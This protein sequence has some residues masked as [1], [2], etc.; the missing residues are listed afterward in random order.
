MAATPGALHF[1]IGLNQLL[2]IDES[3][4]LA[5]LA[6]ATGF[7]RVSCA[8]NLFMR[9]VWPILTLV[10]RETKHVEVGPLVTHPF[11]THPAVI[12]G[13]VAELDEISSGRAFIGIG[14]GAFYD[15]LQLKPE[16]PVTAVRE[17]IEMIAQ[18]L[19]G[20]RR[21][22]RGTVFSLAE[23]AALRWQPPRR[24]MPIVV[25]SWGPK[26]AEI[27]G[28]LAH[29]IDVGFL[30]NLDHIRVVKEHLEL[31]ARR[32]GRDPKSVAVG[33]GSMTAVASD[34]RAAL[35]FARHHLSLF[36]P[37]LARVPGYP[38]VDPAEVEAVESALRRGGP[39]EAARHIGDSTVTALCLAGTPEDLIPRIAELAAAGVR[40]VTF[41]PP[42]GPDHEEAIR[43]IGAKVLPN[44]RR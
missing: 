31:G 42:L 9:P 15:Q 14:R 44:F 17:A 34:R 3:V 29:E 10:A 43:L 39:E 38:R 16:K 23:G 4:R 8:D 11:L 21:G 1:G 6:E 33:C 27:T 25:G 32:V 2:P 19:R 30:L 35:D 36:L 7:D 40:H 22:Y 18:L 24:E 20:D 5:R 12:A 28:E 37:V 26:L 41:C 13:F